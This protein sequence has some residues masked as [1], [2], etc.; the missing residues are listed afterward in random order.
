MAATIRRCVHSV[1]RQLLNRLKEWS[2]GDVGPVWIDRA[3]QN[4]RDFAALIIDVSNLAIDQFIV[5][6]AVDKP[7]QRTFD[8]LSVDLS[9]F[10]KAIKAIFE[11]VSD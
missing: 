8:F 6:H 7:Q 5:I 9:F 3:I 11:I 4:F 1:A 2:S 10:H